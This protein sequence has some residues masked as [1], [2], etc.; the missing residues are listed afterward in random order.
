MEMTGLAGDRP[1]SSD[2][3]FLSRDL[4]GQRFLHAF[5]G[6]DVLDLD[7][8]VSFDRDVRIDT[9]TS[10]L[11]R[12]EDIEILKS[13]PQFIQDRITSYNVCYTKLLRFLLP[14]WFPVALR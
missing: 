4:E 5:V 9:D 14:H 8:F 7:T 1:A 12:I 11:F 3:I 2:Q 10:F 6:G 13:R